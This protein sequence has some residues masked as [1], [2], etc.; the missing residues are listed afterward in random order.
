M[1]RVLLQ[2]MV[3]AIPGDP[4]PA[5]WADFDLASFSPE[6]KTLGLPAEF[7]HVQGMVEGLL[8]LSCWA[9]IG[10]SP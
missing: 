3:E 5:N 6:K 1:T 9:D 8:S 7:S 4:L 2:R 10:V